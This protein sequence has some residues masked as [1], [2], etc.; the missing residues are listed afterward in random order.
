MATLKQKLVL[1]KMVDFGGNM[2]KA[3]LA[4]GYSPAMAKNPQKLTQS[5]GWKELM[6]EYFPDEELVM[7]TRELL[8]AHKLKSMSF[9]PDFSDQ[10][11][12][13]LF[14]NRGGYEI[15]GIAR[16]EEIVIIHYLQPDYTARTGTIDMIYRLK[17]YYKLA[18]QQ[19]MYHDPNEDLS[20]EELD[21]KIR[22]LEIRNSK[23][24]YDEAI[25]QKRDKEKAKNQIA[26]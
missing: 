14:K 21:Q 25:R 2:G 20:D 15:I 3:M 9:S 6:G 12:K 22:E 1:K 10:Y 23:N 8:F 17:G 24:R 26:V 16:S 13:E 18:E 19:Q 5:K 11:I 4:V 7:I